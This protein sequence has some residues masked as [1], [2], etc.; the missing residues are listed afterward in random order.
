MII[1]NV[2]FYS[3]FSFMMHKFYCC[4]FQRNEKDK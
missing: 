4:C 2:V 3:Y 1:G